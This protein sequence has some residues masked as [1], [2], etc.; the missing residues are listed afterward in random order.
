MA[1]Y[2]AELRGPLPAEQTAAAPAAPAVRLTV[3]Q[4]VRVLLLAPDQLTAEQQAHLKHLRQASPLVERAYTLAHQFQ[5]IV[6]ERR[7]SE[8]PKWLEEA[9]ASEVPGLRGFVSGLKK[10]LAAVTAGVNLTVAQRP[11]RRAYQS[12]QTDQAPNVWPGQT[13]S[14]QASDHASSG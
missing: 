13:R 6:R 2:V 7:A 8:F 3:T 14:A 12:A 11:D 9:Q 10:D 1:R 5:T 4:A